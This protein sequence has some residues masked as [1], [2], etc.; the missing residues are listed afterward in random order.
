[1]DNLN[2]LHALHYHNLGLNATCISNT[3]TEHNFYSK[4]I[5]KVPCHKWK[6]LKSRRQSLDE[7]QNY[8]WNTSVGV[9]AV[10]GYENLHLIDIDGC[11]SSNFL[12]NVLQILGLP[13]DYEW[14]VQTGSLNGYHIYFYSEKFE[15]L[16]D[17]DVVSTFP[18]NVANE[19]LFDKI[20]VLWNTHAVLP[21]SVHNSSHD[22]S[23]INCR[24]PSNKPRRIEISKFETIK[25]KYLNR[26]KEII[27]TSYFEEWVATENVKQPSNQ[28]EIDLG[29]IKGTLFLVF[30]IETDGLVEKNSIGAS[31]YP[32]I[33]Q[34][35]WLIMDKDGIVYKKVSDLVKTTFNEKSEAF[36]INRLNTERISQ[37]GKAPKSIYR[38]FNSDLKYCKYIAAH[39]ID[40][41]LPILKNEMEKSFIESEIHNKEKVCTMK[42]GVSLFQSEYDLKPKYPKLSE[43]FEKLF[44]YKI[45]Q[46]HS[47][48]ADVLLTSKCL[49]ELIKRRLA[50]SSK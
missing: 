19:H 45:N 7:L 25:N 18:S 9:G 27:K 42:S 26:T 36:K 32:S 24:I 47:A 22:Y 28:S 20:E 41:D 16:K 12:S 49:R 31:V 3:V 17:D 23:F 44:N 50:R 15:E 29:K 13:L 35:S 21:P 43:L 40:F 37:L 2:Y 10:A 8:S 38:E 6:D 30:D 11:I 1:M 34:I 46:I 5:L 4:N 48:Q 39:N 33:V 14:V